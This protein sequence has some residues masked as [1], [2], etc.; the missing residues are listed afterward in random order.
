MVDT[1][2]SV[3]AL[4]HSA[5]IVLLAKI[6]GEISG[7]IAEIF[8]AR[9]LDP[10]IYGQISL[11]YTIVLSLGTIILLGIHE[12]V[13]RQFSAV[14][15]VNNKI[16]F[17]LSGYSIILLSGLLSIVAIYIF[18]LHIEGVM[19][20]DNLSTFL[21]IFLPFL[22]L[23]PISKVSF[24]T[25]R[26]QKRTYAAVIAQYFGGRILPFGIL[27]LL[28]YI[29]QDYFGAIIYWISVPAFTAFIAIYFLS[30]KVTIDD[31]TENKPNTQTYSKLWS[32]SWPLAV[33][34][35]IFLLLAQLDILMIGYFLKGDSVGYYRVVQPLKQAA[36]FALGA[37]T[38]FFLPLATELFSDNKLD[39]LDDVFKISTKWILLITL[40]PVLLFTIYP[41]DVIRVF[42]GESYLPA[43][44]VLAILIFGLFFRA[45]SGLNGDMVKAINRPKIE[46]YSSIVGLS[47]NFLLNLILIPRLGIVG[48]AIATVIGYLVYNGIELI[49]IHRITGSTPF[50][51]N[52]AK[53]LIFMIGIGVIFSFQLPTADGLIGLISIGILFSL[54]QPIGLVV[55]KSIDEEDVELIESLENRT[56]TDLSVVKWVATKGL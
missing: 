40:P 3:S 19:G 20:V 41:Q 43:A 2:S 52:I 51:T 49:Y 34:S 4:A 30:K 13:T 6:F 36:M 33:G 29:G 23:H 37:F 9:S 44:P 28:I 53:H 38:F 27:L 15:S 32:F 1:Q 10:T 25:L 7:L 8:I 16:Q 5:A 31:L 11:A 17:V 14:D 24:A 55:T 42:F 54:I 26:G 48:G 12:G 39:E 22:L 47:V 21:L 45:V 18:R 56:K 50:S 35:A 46:L